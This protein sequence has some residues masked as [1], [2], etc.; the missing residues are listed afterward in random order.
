M[1]VPK[2]AE[3]DDLPLNTEPGSEINKTEFARRFI[4]GRPDSG[5]TPADILKGFQDAGI[6]I[7]KPYVYA[8]VQR[9][10]EQTAIKKKRGKWFP[11]AESERPQAGDANEIGA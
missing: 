2:S 9:L 6:P 8:L 7:K 4:R 5:A 10:Q 1:D 11:V 3:Q